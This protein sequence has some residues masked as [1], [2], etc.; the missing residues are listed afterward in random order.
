VNIPGCFA[1]YNASTAVDLF[2][3]FAQ[4]T[5]STNI[6]DPKNNGSARN[7]ANCGACVKKCPQ[8]IPIPAQLKR[9]AR[10]L[11]PAPMRW[12]ARLH[13]KMHETKFIDTYA[14]M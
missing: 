13:N 10:K 14:K 1:A 11:E 12:G 2:T 8:N 5:T 9:V 6:V 4:Y 3:G 7:C